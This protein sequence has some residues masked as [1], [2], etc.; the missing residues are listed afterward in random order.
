MTSEPEFQFRA[1]DTWP[2]ELTEKRRRSQFDTGYSATLTLLRREVSH[3]IERHRGTK[4][5]TGP[6]I[7]GL[8]LHDGQI[9]VDRSRPKA[10]ATPEHPGVLL[11]F[12]S[13]HGPLRYATDTFTHWHD[14]LR[15]IALG[16]EALRKVDRYGITKGGEQYRGFAALSAGSGGPT[17]IEAAVKLLAREAGWPGEGRLVTHDQY[18][19]NRD[20]L[21][22]EAQR[23]AHPDGGGTASRFHAVQRAID[24]LR[25]NVR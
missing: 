11:T 5:P 12:A 21:H 25:E 1:I 10:T 20:R 16:L 18:L 6:V 22:R 3:L 4:I 2:G 8:A 7:F 24:F 23:N 15:A 9:T 14:N 17:S 19:L 13:K